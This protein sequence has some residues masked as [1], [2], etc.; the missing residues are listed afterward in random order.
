MG[1]AGKVLVALLLTTGAADRLRLTRPPALC[2]RPSLV[3][4]ETRPRSTALHRAP[5]QVM[6]SGAGPAPIKESLRGL[7]GACCTLY[8]IARFY[9]TPE[10]M[11][12]LLS[13]V[14]NQMM[15]A[16]RCVDQTL[17]IGR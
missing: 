4:Q 8:R 14:T 17:Q 10:R 5:S 16:C 15:R 1:E 6:Y 7:L 13:K 9:G 11:T 12:T 2:L 3:E